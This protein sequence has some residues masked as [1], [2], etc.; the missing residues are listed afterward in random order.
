MIVVHDPGVL[1]SG[2]TPRG[3]AV[4]AANTEHTAVLSRTNDSSLLILEHEL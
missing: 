4:S 1:H 3:R 2:L